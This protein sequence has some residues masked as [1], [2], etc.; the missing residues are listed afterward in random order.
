[1]LATTTA[2][3]AA[4]SPTAT[5]LPACLLRRSRHLHRPLRLPLRPQPDSVRIRPWARQA[6]ALRCTPPLHLRMVRQR[7]LAR[8]RPTAERDL[9]D[10]C[11]RRRRRIPSRRPWRGSP[12]ASRTRWA[13]P[14]C[15]R[16]GRASA[17][18]ATPTS[19]RRWNTEPSYRTARGR[20]SGTEEEK[21]V[22]ASRACTCSVRAF[23]CFYPRLGFASISRN[24][25]SVGTFRSR[26]E[27]RC[28]RPSFAVCS[29][30]PERRDEPMLPRFPWINPCIC[31]QFPCVDLGLR[32]TFRQGSNLIHDVS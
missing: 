5:V 28:L 8:A 11:P 27:T 14:A 3:T 24:S 25:S 21:A 16:P 4:A 12:R 17:R 22:S 2:I 1:M 30:D 18:T 6:A 19:A 9:A 31:G 7:P 32:P 10:Q 29:I 20:S 26:N 15:P 23:T 13:S